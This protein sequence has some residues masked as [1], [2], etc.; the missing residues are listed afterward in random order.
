MSAWWLTVLLFVASAGVNYLLRPKLKT[1]S[2]PP[3][4]KSEIEVPTIEEGTAIPILWGT[5]KLKAPILIWCGSKFSYEIDPEGHPGVIAYLMGA[6]YVWC[7]GPI[8]DL[9]SLQWDDKE[10]VF[11]DRGSKYPPWTT[12]GTELPYP[13]SRGDW[14]EFLYGYILEHDLFDGLDAEGGIEGFYHLWWG[15]EDQFGLYSPTD[16]YN[17]ICYSDLLGL[18]GVLGFYQGT[19]PYIKPH[20]MVAR[21]CPNQLGLTEGRHVIDGDANPSCMLYELLTD[22]VW[23]LG[24]PESLVNQA[25]FQSAGNALAL[26]DFGLSMQLTTQTDAEVAI[27]EILRHIDG[28][29]YPDHSTGLITLALIRNDYDVDELVEISDDDVLELEEFDRTRREAL[30]NKILLRYIDREQDYQ[31]KVATALDLAGVQ[32][33]GGVVPQDMSFLGISKA[34]LAQRVAARELKAVAY[35][36]ASIRLKVNRKAW[37]FRPGQPF[38][39]SSSELGISRMVCRVVRVGFGSLTDGAIRLEA[40]EDAF[41][42]DWTAY[43][44]PAPSQWVFPLEPAEE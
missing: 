30:A 14:P 20:S 16:G 29:I 35:Q 19:S 6:K 2:K 21:R 23:G 1:D 33:L 4:G 12:P 44:P 7:F 13:I 31:E 28:V 32:S 17:R 27:N 22:Q 37:A 38:V 42:V 25:S 26:E 36:F 15:T 41:G 9:I 18:P 24:I 8:D 40:V 34:A 39:F 10:V 3:A 43:S 11:R 5:C